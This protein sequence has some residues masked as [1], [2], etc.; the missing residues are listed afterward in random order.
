MK[1]GTSGSLKES[2]P[3]MC[4]MFTSEVFVNHCLNDRKIARIDL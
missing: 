3:F 1:G 4:V 2:D